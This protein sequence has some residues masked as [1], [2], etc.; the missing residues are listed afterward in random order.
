MVRRHVPQA[1]HGYPED[2]QPGAAEVVDTHAENPEIHCPTD[3]FCD[4]CCSGA[5]RL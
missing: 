4:F 5:T 3:I 2:T 1:Q